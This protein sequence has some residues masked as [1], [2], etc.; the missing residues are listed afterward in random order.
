MNKRSGSVRIAAVAVL[1]W[2]AA[3][4]GV[5]NAEQSG[6][7]LRVVPH[8]NL[9]II[10]P[11]WTTAYITQEH[12][13]MVYDTLFSQDAQGGFQPQMVDRYEITPDKKTWTFTLRDGLEFHDGSPV[14]TD[15]VIASLRR[16]GQ[17]DS[18]GITLLSVT[19]GFD[20][21]DKK[22]FRIKLKE[23]YALMLDALGKSSTSVPFIMP[24]RIAET[25]ADKQISEVIG[26]GPFIFAKD[27]WK[28]GE[29]IVYLKNS[30]Y[31]PRSEPSNGLAGGKVPRVDRVEWLI[32]KDPQT[33]VNALVAG[34]IDMIEA[35]AFES[36]AAFKG[37]PDIELERNAVRRQAMLRFNHLQPPFDNV[38]VRQAAMVALDQTPLLR[39]QVGI[40]TMFGTCFSVY[41][42]GSPLATGKGMEHIGRGDVKAAKA[43]LKEAGYNGTP[44]V[45]MQPTDLAV[46]ARFP[47][48]AAQLLRQAGFKVDLQAMDWQT[49][50]SRR[51]KKDPPGKGGWNV[52]ITN[53]TS[54]DLANPITHPMVAGSCDKAWFGW[55]CDAELE[56]SRQAF[57]RAGSNAERKALAEQVQ[58]RAME[59]G[60]YFPIGEYWYPR[61]YRRNIRGVIEAF[62]MVLWNVDK[63]QRAGQT[64]GTLSN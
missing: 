18:L 10:D 13:Y 17:R 33:Q 23:P 48:M 15:D 24:K 14:T 37:N 61:A 58:V 52:L 63:D 54:F 60:T 62:N 36:F 30:K 5:A 42:C 16:W 47:V 44:V 56:R 39:A 45:I 12:G 34:E 64:P 27:E 25:P 41:P 57:L 31:K 53:F 55:P 43:L 26:S 28:P 3:H 4:P 59:V 9:T 21:V 19:E 40:P 11:V 51:A 50:V 20:A 2:C 46:L 32:I 38:K 7:V 8:S 35:P 1:A 49:L 22:T 6:K 29:K